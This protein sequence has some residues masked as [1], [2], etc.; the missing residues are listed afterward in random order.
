MVPEPRAGRVVRSER[1]VRLGDVT[2]AGRLRLD[3]L[4]RYLQDIAADD[5]RDAALDGA[6]AWVVRR[7]ELHVHALPAF[8]EQVA[9][10][11]WCGGVGSHWAER[12]TTVVSPGGGHVEAATLWVKVDSKT[13]RPAR[14][15]DQ[16]HRIYGEA[17][18]GRKVS[19]RLHHGDPTSSALAAAVPWPL[20]F[21]DFD[22]LGHVNNAAGWV[23]VEEVLSSERSLRPPMIA[24]VEHRAAIE[25]GA[26]VR[27]AVDG[28]DDGDTVRMWLVDGS[29]DAPLSA[30]ISRIVGTSPPVG[31]GTSS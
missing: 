10:A 26:D 9:L 27:I 1:L 4:V 18:G 19:A 13:M 12:R 14:V 5:S 17:G 8:H 28:A 21:A 30:E 23:P 6:D 7:T 2:P 11:T 25:R 3:A 24:S 20:R 16:F 15:D 31:R 29:G 22:A